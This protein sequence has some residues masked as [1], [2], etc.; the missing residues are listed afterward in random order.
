MVL[1]VGG[2]HVNKLQEIAHACMEDPSAVIL[3]EEGD[4]QPGTDVGT[5]GPVF[6]PET[7]TVL[8]GHGRQPVDTISM[9]Q[10]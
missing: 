9:I 6:G 8:G 3:M 7:G 4:G 2:L 10:P 5:T 1:P